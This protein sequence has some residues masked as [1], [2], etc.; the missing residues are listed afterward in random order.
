MSTL[1]STTKRLQGDVSGYSQREEKKVSVSQHEVLQILKRASTV[2]KIQL[3]LTRNFF[4]DPRVLSSD[5][6]QI[7]QSLQ[8]LI[9]KLGFKFFER[10]S[11]LQIRE[12]IKVM[13]I[14]YVH[15]GDYL[16]HQGDVADNVYFIFDGS[17][18]VII[19]DDS[20]IVATLGPGQTFGE[21]ALLYD[22]TRQA[23]IRC[24]TATAIG[25]IGRGPFNSSVAH[26]RLLEENCAVSHLTEV[27]PFCILTT[28]NIIWLAATMFLLRVYQNHVID[29][30]ELKT[31]LI[32]P[33][34]GQFEIRGKV[35]ISASEVLRGRVRHRVNI[36][37]SERLC[38][39]VHEDIPLFII[40]KGHFWGDDLLMNPGKRIDQVRSW[41][42]SISF[43]DIYCVSRHQGKILT[44]HKNCFAKLIG[45]DSQ[46]ENSMIARSKMKFV[47]RR[48]HL[49]QIM[50]LLNRPDFQYKSAQYLRLIL[51][52]LEESIK[53]PDKET[54]AFDT[55]LLKDG[56]RQKEKLQKEEK[57]SNRLACQEK[58][59]AAHTQAYM[60]RLMHKSKG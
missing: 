3:S 58:M 57:V 30:D 35:V 60:K 46:F 53:Q 10:F 47:S 28:R 7:H 2:S 54:S 39:T 56:Q 18:D 31:M 5:L 44:L 55:K 51:L 25:S 6:E 34:D 40:Q 49:Q 24:K 59:A 23:S 21:L 20:E 36:E 4:R 15:E 27:A 14:R 48:D 19:N 32:M 1:H 29:A 12:L 38:D 45:M 11:E 33:V 26:H 50:L 43:T 13:E 9:K 42:S 22:T 37:N 8:L 41:L 16:F 52:L 17:V